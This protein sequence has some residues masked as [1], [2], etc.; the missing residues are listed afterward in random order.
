MYVFDNN[1]E[2]LYANKIYKKHTNVLG[3]YF[4]KTM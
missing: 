3:R 1:A 4:I 2:H